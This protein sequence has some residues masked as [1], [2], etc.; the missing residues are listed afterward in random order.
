MRPSLFEYAGGDGPFLA[1]ARA[2]HARCLADPVL[3][4]PFS[5]ED[6]H[7]QHVE[8]LA[9]YWAEVLGGPPTYSRECG[10]ESGL[11][12][13]HVCNEDITEFGERFLDCFVRA[14]DDAGLPDDP[15]FR[16]AMRAY[17]RWAVDNM[18]TYSDGQ[19]PVPGDAAIPRWG[20]NGVE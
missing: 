3:N 1:L 4:H 6:Q 15:E 8:R 9:A 12:Q 18:L 13:L 2:H 19:T 16:A 11:L 7:P 17:M 10:D 14:L 5:N 20:W